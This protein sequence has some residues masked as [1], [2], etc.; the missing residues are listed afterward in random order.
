LRFV[1]ERNPHLCSKAHL[2]LAGCDL[3]PDKAIGILDV[4]GQFL[5]II[6]KRDIVAGRHFK[7]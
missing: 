3:A 5:P 4:D 7:Y 2:E 1:F 6:L